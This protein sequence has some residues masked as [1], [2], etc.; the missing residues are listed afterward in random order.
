[1]SLSVRARPKLFRQWESSN[2]RCTGLQS[3]RPQS[4]PPRFYPEKL[5]NCFKATTEEA[6]LA[7]VW[8][9]HRRSQRLLCP[10]FLP[11]PSF[12]LLPLT[13]SPGLFRGAQ[14]S[15]YLFLRHDE[16]P[17]EPIQR[18]RFDCEDRRT[19]ERPVKGSRTTHICVHRNYLAVWNQQS[20]F[21]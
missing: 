18:H 21:C 19:A 10:L 11:L 8:S 17:D 16:L 1:M 20:E 3:R 6:A 2:S 5:R 14:F 12:P 15:C 7:L 13:R 9:A 4:L